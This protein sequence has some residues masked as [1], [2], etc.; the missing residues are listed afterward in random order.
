[1]NWNLNKIKGVFLSF[2]FLLFLFKVNGQSKQNFELGLSVAPAVNFCQVKGTEW[3]S[4]INSSKSSVSN[5]ISLQVH[6][7]I[8][9][10]IGK[11]SNVQIGLGY[12]DL[13]FERLQQ[14]L[15]LSDRTYPG[16][17]SG[18]IPDVSSMEK[19]I[20]YTYHFRNL[21]LPI[22]WNGL[23]GH[24]KD[25]RI[26][27]YASAGA[28][29]NTLLSHSLVAETAQGYLIDSQSKFQL[30]SS[31]FN[32]NRINLAF[33]VGLKGVY[34]LDKNKSLFVQPLIGYFP[35]S[36]TSSSTSVNPI[37]LQVNVGLM[38]PFERK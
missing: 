11:N 37:L 5:Y 25:F 15:Q 1:M 8:K 21:Q 17:G 19:K 18:V 2:A 22:I 31:G 10:S 34:K 33:Q 9:K 30:D 6:A 35:F 16:I 20:T 28:V 29:L 4:Y 36:I 38:L 23:V 14:N 32:P 24:S 7:W 26:K 27:F 13:G 3:E 12:A